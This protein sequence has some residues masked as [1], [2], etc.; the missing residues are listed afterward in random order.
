TSP[1][2][3]VA[4]GDGGALGGEGDAAP[5]AAKPKATAAAEPKPAP[6]PAPP[7]K[8]E[9]PAAGA[10]DWGINVASYAAADDAARQVQQLRSA[11]YPA[12]VQQAQ[13]RTQTWHRVQL[14]GYGSAA[15]ARAAA[16]ELQTRFGYRGLWVVRNTPAGHPAA[17]EPAAA[18]APEQP[19]HDTTTEAAAPR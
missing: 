13:V 12:S 16:D 1:E 4:V 5:R 8:P 7:H 10:E 3:L 11:G 14:R 9:A 17:P 2:A 19:G 18:A 15:A 6:P